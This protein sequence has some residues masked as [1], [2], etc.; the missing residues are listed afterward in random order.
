ADQCRG[1]GI[2]LPAA[3]GTAGAG[4]AVPGVGAVMTHL[5]AQSPGAFQQAAAGQNAAADAGA[6]GNADHIG[7]TL[8][9]T[10]PHFPQAH[11]VGVVGDGDGQVIVRRQP[12]FD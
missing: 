5:S 2:P 8:G 12:I 11:A 1:G 9:G 3:F 7:T 10:D 6:D 4:D